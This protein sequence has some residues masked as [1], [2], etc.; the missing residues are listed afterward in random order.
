M[1][2]VQQFLK[3]H[4]LLADDID[5]DGLLNDFLSEM[6]KGLAG[7][8]SSLKMIP[9]FITIDEG[10][11]ADEP[12]IVI[13]A[14]GTNL[15]MA[16]ISFDS[17][18]KAN[19]DDLSR[20]QMPGIERELSADEFFNAF[21]EYLQP[22]I[23]R[24]EKIGFC[25]SYPADISPDRD[26]RLINWTKDI[27]VPEVE[28]MFVGSGLLD[29]MGEAGSGRRI[30]VLN[31]TIATLLAGKAAAAGRELESYVGLILG[32]G[33][34]IAYVEKNANITKRKDIDKAGS[35][36]INV[37]SGNFAL[38]PQGD[39]DRALDEESSNPGQQ[40][41]EKMIAGLYC[42]D[43]ILRALKSA[44]EEGLFA[45]VCADYIMGIGEL[46]GRQI[47]CFLSGSGN[48]P[49]VSESIGAD[50]AL[51]IKGI[52]EGIYERSSKLTAINISAAVLK[53]GAGLDA[54]RPVCVNIDGST[55]Y[56]SV[57]F[58]GMVEGYLSRI[59]G[60]RGI[61][62]ELVRVDEAPLIGAAVAGLTSK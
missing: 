32:T 3:K 35:Q 38:V 57:G 28:G 46:S 22:I 11:P 41:L 6:E 30:T 12:V 17:S 24:S 26:G 42:G 20:Y 25:F 7:Q 2:K 34:N 61:N 33:T 1:E 45:S 40:R 37:E 23:G 43:M 48:S 36:A 51:I 52:L 62:Y 19:V 15:R 21:V 16:V 49:L 31:D 14:G 4:G 50:D 53:S 47:D 5:I 59:L 56:K 27:K 10:L 18:G 55:Y 39:I 9:T 54:A 13:D 58:R 29:A 60:G 44:A 8:D